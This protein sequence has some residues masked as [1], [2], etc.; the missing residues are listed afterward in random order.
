MPLAVPSLPV[1]QSPGWEERET[2]VTLFLES[3]AF[4]ACLTAHGEL[5]VNLVM[6]N[7]VLIFC[8]DSLIKRRFCN[9]SFE[10]IGV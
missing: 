1:G 5:V 10:S 9:C 4:H 8:Q 2:G 6:A 7:S 3:S